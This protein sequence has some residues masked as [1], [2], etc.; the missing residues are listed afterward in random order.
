M[1]GWVAPLNAVVAAGHALAHEHNTNKRANH[2]HGASSPSDRAAP[3]AHA[4]THVSKVADVER[5]EVKL[6]HSQRV[7]QAQVGG[8]LPVEEGESEGGIEAGLSD[9]KGSIQL[10]ALPACPPA[11]RTPA[12]C[13]VAGSTLAAVLRAGV[14]AGT[15]S[16]AS[17]VSPPAAAAGTCAC[18]RLCCP[19]PAALPLPRAHLGGVAGDGHVVGGGPHLVPGDPLAVL[20]LTEEAHLWARA[21]THTRMGNVGSM[22]VGSGERGRAA[23]AQ[24][25]LARC[26]CT[27]RATRGVTWRDSCCC[28]T[29]LNQ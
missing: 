22:W 26:E 20:D 16:C 4:R 9:S 7:P 27:Q 11:S 17:T 2:N 24:P 15:N 8:G 18:V 19:A 10:L 25:T 13:H 29:W 28:C 23:A 21:H 3:A 14:R 12:S 6:L 1:G 5:V